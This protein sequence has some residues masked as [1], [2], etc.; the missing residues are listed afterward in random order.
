MSD[1]APSHHWTG[2]LTVW[3]GRGRSGHP[4]SGSSSCTPADSGAGA[5]HLA[6]STLLPAG[7]ELEKDI[8]HGA[9]L[10]LMAVP[11][12]CAPSTGKATDHFRFARFEGPVYPAS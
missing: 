10:N 3:Q 2:A 9:H 5:A 7:D 1:L 4:E 12:T 6:A 11:D 8:A